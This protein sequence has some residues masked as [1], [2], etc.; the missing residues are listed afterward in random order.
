MNSRFKKLASELIAHGVQ[1][2]YIARIEARIDLEE[3]L[4]GLQVEHQQEM[5][6]A[7]GKTDVRVNL[8][9]A[10]LELRKALFERAAREGA[11]RIRLADLAA[12][13]N[14]QRLIAFK[15]INELRIHREAIGFR[16]DAIL[17]ELYPIQAKLKLADVEAFAVDA[18]ADAA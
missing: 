15:R 8:A 1:S 3:R 10:E 11:S 4:E 13:F 9:L 16:N 7:L 6:G 5:A 2:Q 12:A 18:L 17:D 14:D